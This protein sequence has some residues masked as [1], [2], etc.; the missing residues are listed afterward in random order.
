MNGPNQVTLA[1]QPAQR[2]TA[3]HADQPDRLHG[4]AQVGADKDGNVDRY[5]VGSGPFKFV[6][7][8]DNSS[9]KLVRNDSYWKKDQPYLDGI[10]STSS[11][12]STC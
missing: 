4:V 12:N 8:Q 1:S 2:R 9:I 10:E 6:E 11:T 5:P 3:D 7:W